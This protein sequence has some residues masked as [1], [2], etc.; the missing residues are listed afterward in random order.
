[1]TA[2]LASGEVFV[3]ARLEVV[4]AECFR[5]SERTLLLG[6][7]HEPL[8]EPAAAPAGYHRI[9]YRE[10][11]FASALHE[12]A[13]WC[14]AGPAR[15]TKRDFGYWYAPAGRDAAA[16]RA[17]EAVEEKPQALEWLF[18]LACGYPFRVS[19]DNLDP[20]TGALPDTRPFCARVL[21]RGVQWQRR[22]L[23]ERAAIFLAALARHFGT[24]VT[25]E[26]LDLRRAELR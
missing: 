5:A 21:A 14:I 3:A 22:G 11:F 10:D 23:P 25:L 20:V 1:M 2:A 26:T 15:R 4:F 17:F 18:S 7:A 6:G 19:V 8:Y 13:H 16:Q 12:V 9:Y 24:G